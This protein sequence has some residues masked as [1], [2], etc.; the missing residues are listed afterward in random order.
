MPDPRTS[1][2]RSQHWLDEIERY[3]K[4]SRKWREDAKRIIDRYRLEGS[5]VE[6]R[7]PVLTA[8]IQL[9]CGLTPRP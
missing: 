9:F 5:N 1:E 7:K 6:S 2:D 4:A 8:D 3:Q